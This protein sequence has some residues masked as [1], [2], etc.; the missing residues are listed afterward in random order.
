[1]WWADVRGDMQRYGHGDHYDGAGPALTAGVDFN[2]GN[3]VFGAFGGYG[4]NALD[5]GLR[6][7]SFDQTDA[8]LG[9]R[10]GWRA[11][12]GWVD[13]QV[14][15]S[16]LEFDIERNVDLGRASRTHR[17]SADGNNLSAGVQGGWEFGSGALRHGPVLGVLSQRIEIDAFAEDQATLSTSLA[18]PEQQ[19]DSLIGSIGWQASVDTGGPLT[20][21]ARVTLDREFEDMPE[22]AFARSQSLTGSGTYAVPGVAFDQRYGSVLLGARTNL[23]GV[24]AN[25]GATLTVGQAGGSHTTL[26]ATFGGSF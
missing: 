8:T 7:G 20:P 15:Y 5:W 24:Q 12:G 16:R 2:R 21:Y 6:G 11:G 4:R 1:Q 13:A 19:F 25:V 9:A 14:S 17:A 22:E 3:V 18:Y 10:A 26:F 23:F